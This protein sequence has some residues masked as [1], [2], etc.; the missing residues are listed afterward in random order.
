MS[1]SESTS[2]PVTV[3]VTL[4][5]NF[6]IHEVMAF[7]RDAAHNLYDIDVIL[8]KHGL[9]KQQ[10]AAIQENKFFQN[11]FN[12]AVKEWNSPQSTE[13]RLRMEAAAAL[14]DALPKVAARMHNTNEPLAAVVATAQL[15][16]KMAGVGEEKNQ[17]NA[18]EKVSITINLGADEKLRYDSATVDV[19]EVQ[20]IPEGAGEG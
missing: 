9:T 18:A 15:F 12:D 7:I 14:E 8:K 10:Y 16:A 19:V 11:A 4:P 1:D 3:P 2:L 6:T 5:D 20:P 13:K 17:G